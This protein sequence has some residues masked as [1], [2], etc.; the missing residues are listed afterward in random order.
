[1]AGPKIINPLHLLQ[2]QYLNVMSLRNSKKSNNNQ[3]TWDLRNA[4]GPS[5][6]PRTGLKIS[7]D[8][9]Y[10]VMIPDMCVESSSYQVLTIRLHRA[11]KTLLLAAFKAD[12]RS[13]ID[14]V[15]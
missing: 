15:T 7:G 2:E 4:C 14:V 13:S 9:T 1:M 10:G 12:L 3:Q 6:D 5:V 11:A 8:R